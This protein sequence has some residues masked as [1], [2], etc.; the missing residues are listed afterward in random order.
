MVRAKAITDYYGDGLTCPQLSFYIVHLNTTDKHLLYE[1]LGDP[2]YHD[3][4]F[5]CTESSIDKLLDRHNSTIGRFS[6]GPFTHRLLCARPFYQSDFDHVIGN[7]QWIYHMSAEGKTFPFVMHCIDNFSK[8]LVTR[9]VDSRG[10][11]CAYVLP[12]N[13][14]SSPIRIRIAHVSDC[15]VKF[16]RRVQASMIHVRIF[17]MPNQIRAWKRSDAW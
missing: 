17:R 5:A 11:A 1:S 12:E 4:R 15:S 6:H 7:V 14:H 10:N 9:T 13:M 2:P 16:S 3:S 8:S